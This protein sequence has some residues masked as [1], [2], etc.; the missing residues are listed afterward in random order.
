[1]LSMEDRH[2]KIVFDILAKYPYTFYAFGSRAKGHPR[3]FSDLDLCY[4]EDIPIKDLAR[5]KED[6]EESSLP[7]KVDLVNWKTC[8]D[9]FRSLMQKDLILIQGTPTLPT[10]IGD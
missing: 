10:S 2:W 1:M 6:F 7:Y 8:D 5:L 4:C 3:Q 9:T